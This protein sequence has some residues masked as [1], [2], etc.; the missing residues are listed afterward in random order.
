[1]RTVPSWTSVPTIVAIFVVLAS[2][3]SGCIDENQSPQGLN[4]AVV[5]G[6]PTVVFDLDARPFPDIP[7]PNDLATRVDPTSPTG[8]RVNVSLLGGS[9]Q[10]ENVRKFVNRMDG[11]GVYSPI[12]VQFDGLLDL[13][14]LVERHQ[15]EIPDFRNDAVFLVNVDIESP[16]YGK[17]EL[18][19]FGLGNYPVLMERPN[20]YF[21]ADPRVDGTNLLFESVAEVDLNDNGILDPIEDTDDDGVWDQ[22]NLLDPAGDPYEP[23]NTLDWYERETNTLILRPVHTLKPG[24]TYAVVLTSELRGELGDPINSPFDIVNHA[25]QTPDLKALKHILPRALPDRFDEELKDVRFAWTFTTQ[26]PFRD[27]LAVRAGLYGHGVFDRLS[28]EFPPELHIVH[29]ATREDVELPRVFDLEPLLDFLVP[30]LPQ[31]FGVAGG[32][33]DKLEENLTNIDY[34][35]NGTFLSPYFLADK[36][37]LAD[38]EPGPDRNPQDD[39]EVIDI[40]SSTGEGFYEP[41]EVTFMC[42]V[43]E[44]N[45]VRKPPFPT[46]IYSHAINS[47]RLETLL[48]GGV[49]AKFGFAVCAIDAVGHGVAIPQ[50][51]TELIERA[52]DRVNIPNFPAVITHHRAR[53]L[54]NDGVPDSGGMFFTSDILH[55][56]DNFRQT[57]IDQ[58]Q[59]IRILRSFDGSKRWPDEIDE[60]SPY[61]QARRGIIAPW[62][63]DGDGV[64][65]IA[66][67]FNGDGVVDF[68]GD[69][70]FV[71]LGTSLG[72]IQTVLLSALEPTIRA[73]VSNAGGGGLVD[74]AYRTTIRNARAGVIL[75]MLGPLIVGSRIPDTDT[76][77]LYF[78]V[79]S[80]DNEA[81][82]PIGQFS[83]IED[84]DRIVLRNPVREARAAVPEDEKQSEVYVRD[85]RFRVSIAAD[86]NEASRRRAL[87]GFDPKISLVDTLMG[88]EDVGRCGDERC[89]TGQACTVDGCV[90]IGEC[91]DSFDHEA[92]LYENDPDTDIDEQ[93]LYRDELTRRTLLD[94]RDHGDPLIL[95]VYGSDGELK[96]TIDEFQNNTF[97]E[98]IFYPPGS[99][100]AAPAA[101]LG[102]KRQTPDF[103]KFIGIAQ[104]LIEGAD[105]A[106][107]AP[108]FFQDPFE[109]PYE[110]EPFRHGHTNL[111]MAGTVGDQTVPISAGIS[112]ARTAGILDV[113]T[114]DARFGTTENQYLIDTFVYEGIY[115]LDRFPDFPSTLFDADDLDEGQFIE[116]GDEPRPNPDAQDPVRATVYTER[117]ISAL[118]LPYL[119]VEGEHTFNAP[120]TGTGF[121]AATHMSNHVGWYLIHRGQRLVDDTCF[122]SNLLE[123]CDFYDFDTFT[124][125][126][127]FS[128]E[129]GGCARDLD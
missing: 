101:G 55:S 94:P 88:C 124:P 116:G 129:T 74:I 49:L 53:D 87:L 84:G 98:N 73:T 19:D 1:M 104:T 119:D 46:V 23:G 16:D 14:N 33:A 29:N 120:I 43:P 56:K 48:F 11:F 76:M 47:T 68:G 30:L 103:R 59:F 20:R 117:G 106:A 10:E 110:T 83:G 6:G 69:Q 41:G 9:E 108:H 34:I 96:M 127:L 54:T 52:T 99:P 121:D 95:E 44:A 109:F 112:V 123:P 4:K 82:V 2:L 40:N 66:G 36:D 25:R 31:L 61:V 118:R 126:D 67:D 17:L 37:G 65:D 18:I 85:G 79:A 107:A 7:F 91:I 78:Q 70:A 64:G 57:A 102:L 122:E 60:E 15:E 50:E 28:E 125:P 51:F 115:W 90:S 86:A 89:E 63:Q 8:R 26:E 100:L 45:E 13:E 21:D 62:D 77:N 80:A 113:S 42:T 24:T 3:A 128:C 105:P 39:D 58:F 32:S 97:F 72:G 5:S 12:T 75:R 38:P 92:V 35:V 114:R 27:L 93:A 71:G 81:R 22:P 111:M